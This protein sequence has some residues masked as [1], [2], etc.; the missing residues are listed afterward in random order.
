V[1]VARPAARLTA[2]LAREAKLARPELLDE[3]CRARLVVHGVGSEAR[4]LRVAELAARAGKACF[5]ARPSLIVCGHLNHAPL[6]ATLAAAA[7]ARLV[8][9]VHGV[10]AEVARSSVKARALRGSHR[11]VAVS[12]FTAEKV[13]SALGVDRARV[14]VIHNAVD[15]ARF[16]PG[17]PS[18]TVEK[19]LGGMARPIL[20]TVA[21]LDA[22]EQYK[23][24]DVTL[25][26]LGKIGREVSYLVV[27][28]GS[29]RARL[30]KLAAGLPVRF[31]GYASDEELP[32]LFRAAD[33]F[34]M[35]SRHEGF[36]R[37]FIEALASGIPVVA[38]AGDGSI[39]A[40]GGGALGLLV[41]P[42]DPDAIAKAI[43]A[44]LDGKSPKTMREPKSLH[45]EVEA[46]FG[47]AAFRARVA[48]LVDQIN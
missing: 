26:A 48:T 9:I 38:G 15:T 46:R 7:R 42:L 14:T 44:H 10:E 23:G 45:D 29:D 47:L 12:G 22:G 27:G 41:D 3:K 4:P 34:V 20:L 1:A 28:E 17:R 36:G 33:C 40:L 16:S 25:R 30:E 39:D 8:T 5:A 11:V 43:S 31:W 32:E 13:T 21:R 2:V 24:V 37:V 6:A 18:S 19:K 35:P